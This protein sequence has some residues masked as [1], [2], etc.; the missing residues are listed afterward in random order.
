MTDDT[1][2]ELPCGRAV[3]DLLDQVAE[4]RGDER[5]EHQRSCSHCAERLDA[6]S[7][8]WA[9]VTRL[10]DDV[11]SAPSGFVER[12]MDRVRSDRP[13]ALVL[14]DRAGT[15]GTS[16]VATDVLALLGSVAA[17]GVAGVAG[18]RSA[19]ADLD[20][21]TMRLDIAVTPRRPPL[22]VAADVRDA[23]IAEV[24]R[25]TALRLRAV[26]V[27]VSDLRG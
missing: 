8:T 2:A 13:G 21:A 15:L 22:E 16:R 25:A 11:V 9:R 4:G 24:E 10:G 3:T 12:V 20:A 17:Y 23:V 19:L 1:R 27:H 7:A 5:D 26:D 18:V 14:D 6:L